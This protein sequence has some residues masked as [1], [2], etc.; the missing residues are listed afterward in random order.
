MANWERTIAVEL[1][2]AWKTH[3]RRNDVK[4]MVEK[5]GFSH[6]VIVR[7][8]KYGHVHTPELPDLINKYFLSRLEE[9]KKQAEEMNEK[10][11]ELAA[12]KPAKRKRKQN[13]PII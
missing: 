9:E 2:E 7:A 11:A 4:N 8:L 10:A 3:T 13:L 12:L 6:P 1:H 5:L